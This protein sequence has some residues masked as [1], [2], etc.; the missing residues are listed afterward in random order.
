MRCLLRP[1]PV[2]NAS[3]LVTFSR[4]TGHNSSESFSY[5]Q[6]HELAD[7]RDL[8]ASLCGIG[9]E[10]VYVGPSEAL[11]PAGAAWVSGGYFDTLG[12]DAVC[13]PAVECVGRRARCAG[14]RR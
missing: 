2:P 14:Q 10:T 7:R 8:F 3:E 5:P 13:R 12:I 4:W 9:T 11:E 6:I 1:L